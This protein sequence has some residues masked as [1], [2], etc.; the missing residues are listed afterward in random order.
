MVGRDRSSFLNDIV[1]DVDTDMA[2]ISDSKK[3]QIVVYD[4]K[5]DNSWSISHQP[6]TFADNLAVR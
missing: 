2:Y 4:S 6:T 3:G 5:T 1:L